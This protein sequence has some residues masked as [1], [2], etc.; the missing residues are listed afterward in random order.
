MWSAAHTVI[1]TVNDAQAHARLRRCG[2]ADEVMALAMT[3]A[4]TIVAAMATSA[5]LAARDGVVRLFHRHGHTLPAIEAQLD[6]DAEVVERDEN[7]D[8]A[9]EDLAGAW[10]R[11]L[12]A[13]LN[14]H[15]E[16]AADLRVLV[17]LVAGQLPQARQGWVQTN[18]ARQGGQVFAAQ[19]GNVVVHRVAGP[20]PQAPMSGAD[21]EGIP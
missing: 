10:K 21:P 6:G 15:P 16:A 20:S 12:A 17:E 2:V 1:S 9:R 4:S 7:A 19:G 13:L 11:R 14:E 3:G 18:I 8:G 5:W